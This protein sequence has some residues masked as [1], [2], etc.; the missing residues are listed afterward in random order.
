MACM[1]W[2]FDHP[3]QMENKESSRIP[4]DMP[5]F[6]ATDVEYKLEESKFP[7]LYHTMESSLLIAGLDSTDSGICMSTWSSQMSPMEENGTTYVDRDLETDTIIT[8]IGEYTRLV[9]ICANCGSPFINPL[10]TGHF[11]VF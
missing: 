4:Y 5:L 11:S 3:C 1:C 9:D 6:V 2:D 8:L 7:G 10:A